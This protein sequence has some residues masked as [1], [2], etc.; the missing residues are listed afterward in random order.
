MM[1]R[2]REAALRL[3][4][5]RVPPKKSVAY[6]QLAHFKKDE[7]MLQVKPKGTDHLKESMNLVCA[8][9]EEADD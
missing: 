1:G 9:I 3:P 2:W 6:K 5:G 8:P 7:T 4:M